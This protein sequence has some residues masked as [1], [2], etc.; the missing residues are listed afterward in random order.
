MISISDKF[1]C[2]GCGACA[3]I[4]KNDSI[5]MT[6]DNEGF[7]YPS[8]N[9]T[10]CIGCGLCEKVCPVINQVDGVMFQKAYAAYAN[11]FSVRRQSS[12]GG[13]F[14]ILAKHIIHDNG[15]V[16]GAAFNA[17]LQVEHICVN[18]IGGLAKLRMSKY[19]QSRIG[20]TFELAKEFLITGKK[21]LFTGTPCQVSGLKMYLGKEYD[22]LFTQDIICFGVP[23]PLLWNT[24]KRFVDSK[25]DINIKSVDYRNKKDGW[26]NYSVKYY[27]EK[28]DKECKYA[29]DLYLRTYFRRICLRPSCYD[30]QFKKSNRSSDITLGD[31]WG[32]ENIMPEMDDGMGTSLVVCNTNKGLDFFSSVL[33]DLS[34]QEVD[35]NR[36]IEWN[37]MASLSAKK[38]YYRKDF[39]NYL[40]KH[41]YLKTLNHFNENRQE[42]VNDYEEAKD[43]KGLFYALFWLI[44]NYHKYR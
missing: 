27:G 22:N 25:Y 6:P 4:C 39:Y 18:N 43:K 1:K 12:S 35:Y 26:K 29:D 9:H 11:D 13:V 7:L 10:K 16:F 5:F 14:S 40:L 17:D 34:C 31:F 8:V 15:V 21:V 28:K 38:E 32:I 24:H 2:T 3:N 44:K 19:V 36:A 37:P 33:F 42:F 23:S 30:C 41:S 20:N